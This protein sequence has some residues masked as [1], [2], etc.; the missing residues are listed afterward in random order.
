[1]A[2][3]PTIAAQMMADALAAARR[4]GWVPVIGLLTTDQMTDLIDAGHAASQLMV[5]LVQGT[6]TEEAAEVATM[7][8]GGTGGT[9]SMPFVP[10]P[11]PEGDEDGWVPA[12]WS[13]HGGGAAPTPSGRSTPAIVKA[14]PPGEL[15]PLPS[16]P[17][18]VPA[19][20]TT[21]PARADYFID[22]ATK[23]K[24][25][26]LLASRADTWQVA[27][28]TSMP[29]SGTTTPAQS[30]RRGPPNAREIVAALNV[31]ATQSRPDSSSTS[32]GRRPFFTGLDAMEEASAAA[33]GAAS[34][35]GSARHKAPPT[36]LVPP[37]ALVI[38]PNRGGGAEAAPIH[39]GL[40]IAAT[41][42]VAAENME[43]T[44]PVVYPPT[45]NPFDDPPMSTSASHSTAAA[46]AADRPLPQTSTTTRQGP[47]AASSSASSWINEAD[48]GDVPWENPL[49]A[50]AMAR[51]AAAASNEE[52]PYIR[53]PP[54]DASRRRSSVPTQAM[55]AER[56][57]REASAHE[58]RQYEAYDPRRWGSTPWTAEEVGHIS[59]AYFEYKRQMERAGAS[60]EDTAV[61]P[62]LRRFAYTGL[63]EL[64]AMEASG[65]LP[66]P[67][68]PRRG[69]DPPEADY[70]FLRR[71]PTGVVG[72]RITVRHSKE[73]RR[74]VGWCAHPCTVPHRDAVCGGEGRCLRP[75]AL[76]A[77]GSH[78][79]SGSHKC[80]AC[81]PKG[82]AEKPPRRWAAW[83][84]RGFSL[85]PALAGIDDTLTTELPAEIHQSFSCGV[86]RSST[87]A[88]DHAWSCAPVAAAGGGAH[89]SCFAALGVVLTLATATPPGPARR[90]TSAM[91]PHRADI[92]YRRPA[93]RASLQAALGAADPQNT[94]RAIDELES[95]V[96]ASTTRRS[97]DSRIRFWLKIAERHGVEPWP[98]DHYRIKLLAACL[99]DGGYKSAQLYL[100]AA[101]YHHEHVLQLDVPPALKKAARRFARAAV[102]G[103]PGSKLKQA[104][105]L[106]VLSTL[107]RF[108]AAPEPL[109]C[110]RPHHAV[111]VVIIAC[112]FMLRE[113]E[114]AGARVQDL[115]L[116]SATF[117]GGITLDLPLHKT[118][119][120]GQTEL[121]R[122]SLRCVCTAVI[123]PLCPA[124]AA[125]RHVAR[126][127]A[128][129]AKAP[130]SALFPTSTTEPRTK[131][132]SIEMFLLV[133][134]ACGVETH[135]DHPDG[136]RVP[137]FG[138]HAARVSGATF[139]AARG[140]AIAIIQLLGRW[141]SA[142]VERY[143]QSAPLTYA[144]AAIPAQALA[145]RPA[146]AA[147]STA[148]SSSH[149]PLA[150][151]APDDDDD[152]ER[153]TA[154]SP[155]R[156][157]DAMPEVDFVPAP[158]RPA[159]VAQVVG[160]NA[161]RFIMN[162]RSKI[163]HLPGADETAT[164]KHEWTAKCGWP[165]GIRQ[166]F[167]LSA[168]PPDP[169]RCQ[170]CFP[171][172]ALDAA[173]EVGSSDGSSSSSSEGSTSDSD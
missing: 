134:A 36:P 119:Q 105:D 129:G 52:F 160:E 11:I 54:A 142:A 10:T 136:R 90:P 83:I 99:K 32:A 88:T 141:A 144:A 3:H 138:G 151:P 66:R 46:S 40:G 150:L 130:S 146:E 2:L 173:T 108:Q 81:E 111:D 22:A 135:M 70:P 126:L 47:E 69:E 117:G 168:E 15:A 114:I 77:A 85:D 37:T 156:S 58:R 39:P 78:G 112:W 133:L 98:L 162:A 167:R 158:L 17:P 118:A 128:D 23:A 169:R 51:I 44:E 61:P 56:R 6:T 7:T 74:I 29:S 38:D 9:G 26:S 33:S 97:V 109:D 140:V 91:V 73:E 104:F 172:V 95:A 139:L 57:R 149:S 41:V 165:Y 48:W 131:A 157:P 16:A 155:T 50:Q 43:T 8:A 122:R 147:G 143:T 116:S 68:T 27:A 80:R 67:V 123:H 21:T 5:G 13:F 19:S 110:R 137:I 79:S 20:G 96:F 45:P 161:T 152:A 102:R 24:A 31:Q 159:A 113:V 115:T 12:R 171:V 64:R 86:R 30:G 60:A 42:T 100:D 71:L 101:I 124:C 127:H 65:A 28:L 153:P 72:A 63:G 53:Q 145:T 93:Q 82:G 34:P 170:R 120:R 103:M 49:D 132:A 125:R 59:P 84:R 92:P 121:T 76:G 154:A 164:E 166:F 18:S 14:T 107:V 25:T 87:P 55:R 94:Q 163:V 35:T 75:I 89:M 4:T 106:G 62:H 1:M 148:A